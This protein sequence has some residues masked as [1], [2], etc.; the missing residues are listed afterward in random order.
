MKLSRIVP[1]IA[2]FLKYYHI[3]SRAFSRRSRIATKRIQRRLEI[4][5]SEYMYL[6][7]KQPEARPRT[8]CILRSVFGCRELKYAADAITNAR[9][10]RQTLAGGKCM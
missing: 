4:S 6:K 10:I 9:S 1:E 8:R 5:V 3:S 7:K 2:I